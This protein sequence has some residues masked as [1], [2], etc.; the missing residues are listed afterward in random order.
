MTVNP[1]HAVTE[2]AAAWLATLSD[3]ACTAEERRAFARWLK[4]SSLNVEEFLTVSLL[5]R[6]LETLPAWPGCDVDRLIA[7]A[8]REEDKVA[9]FPASPRE[10]KAARSGWS[11]AAA[12]VV[13]LVV[14]GL[15]LDSAGWLGRR[16]YATGLGELRS[17]ALE[18]GSIVQLDAQSRIR[19]RFDGRE[20]RIE[21]QRGTALFKVAHDAGRPF[22]VSTADADILAVGTAFN[23]AARGARTVVTVMEGRVRVEQRSASAP[24]GQ[25]RQPDRA[26]VELDPGQQIVIEPRKAP[27]QATRVDPQKITAWTARRLYFD[28]TPLAEAAEEFS[29]Y[30]ARTIRIEDPELARRRITGAFDAADPASLVAFLQRYAD[31]DVDPGREGW[32]VRR[33]Q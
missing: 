22:R 4:R 33:T 21:L 14:S 10:R 3:P 13:A 27:V 31:T 32:V 15:L 29:R 9:P 6:R 1:T 18:D 26:P 28:E 20:R 23:V 16:T 11:L 7:E 25:A 5:A 17:V 30:S 24:R 19:A 12:A 8:R 2:E